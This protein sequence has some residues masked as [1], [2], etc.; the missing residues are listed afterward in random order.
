MGLVII[1]NYDLRLGLYFSFW[2]Y[3]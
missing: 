2:I 3:S 1:R